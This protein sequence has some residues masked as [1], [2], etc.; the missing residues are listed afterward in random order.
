MD[1][2]AGDASS[3]SLGRSTANL[4]LANAPAKSPIT[5]A[6]YIIA[7]GHAEACN[8]RGVGLQWLDFIVF[9]ARPSTVFSVPGKLI[10]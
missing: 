3:P 5:V 10:N 1:N 2:L 4:L 9:Y 6:S 7:E 8:V